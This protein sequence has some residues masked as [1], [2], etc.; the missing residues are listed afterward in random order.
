[1][2]KN[3]KKVIGASLIAGVIA[4]SASVTTLKTMA[5]TNWD[6]IYKEAYDSVML[7]QK[8]QSQQDINK[9]RVNIRKMT[10]AW[11]KGFVGEFS[12]QVDTVQQ[13][14]FERFY[15]LLYIDGNPNKPKAIMNQWDIDEARM[16]IDGFNGDAS[17]APYVP[18]WSSAVDRYQDIHIKNA[19][20]SV[21]LVKTTMKLNDAYEAY[22]KIDIII[23]ARN[24]KT[25][26]DFGNSLK[27]TL[28]E[29]TGKISK[30][31]LDAIKFME[32]L[33]NININSLSSS[34][35]SSLKQRLQEM[36]TLANKLD[37]NMKN[38]LLDR[39]SFCESN[40]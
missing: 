38:S 25:V 14:I 40:M 23:N 30:D 15:S 8:S 20:D 29:L 34:E 1:M 26:S 33:D 12:R 24:N 7:V 16:F 27:Q 28:H 32:E 9:A 39:I 31:T 3:L 4:F 6:A 35:L 21:E 11:M 22:K 5:S 19:A 17:N 18:A 36:K 37:S 13:K 2:R 10:P